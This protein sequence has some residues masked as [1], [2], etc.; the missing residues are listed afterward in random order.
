M[1]AARYVKSPRG[2]YVCTHHAMGHT[3]A[4]SHMQVAS[5]LACDNQVA[6]S[7]HHWLSQ[8]SSSSTHVTGFI[9][10]LNSDKI[11]GIVC[12][13]RHISL[14]KFLLHPPLPPK[15][16][17]LLLQAV[18]LHHPR[19]MET[20]HLVSSLLDFSFLLCLPFPPSQLTLCPCM[21]PVY[22]G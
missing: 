3:A 17:R 1:G 12:P 5:A 22:E 21:S 4:I 11:G 10:F 20:S 19:S 9:L 7:H 2:D 18:R 6:M 15:S 13:S 8:E 14:V 16:L